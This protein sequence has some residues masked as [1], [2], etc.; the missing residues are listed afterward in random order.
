MVSDR[1]EGIAYRQE[2]N[3]WIILEGANTFSCEVSDAI[4]KGT[5]T[6]FI[7]GVLAIQT[8]VEDPLTYLRGR[9]RELAQN[10]AAV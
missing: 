2:R 7:G 4:A 3:G 5:H 6:I 9:Y 10:H 8:S 1:F